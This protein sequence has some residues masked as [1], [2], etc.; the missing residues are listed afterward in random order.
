MLTSEA[1]IQTEHPSRYLIRLCRHADSIGRKLLQ[2]HP[3]DAQPRPQ[4][5]RVKWS[6]TAG[7]L[8]L[9]W[10]RCTMQAGP[11]TLTVRA[12]ATNEENLQ[13]IQDLIT[14]NLERFGRRDHLRVSWQRPQAPAVQAD[15]AG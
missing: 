9:N 10:G 6:D 15:T 12:E 11:D 4:V 7:T 2:L 3:G 1:R 8:T 5:K 13:R 14:R